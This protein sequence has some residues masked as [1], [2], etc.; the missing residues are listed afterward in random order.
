MLIS[1]SL[2][3]HF[4]TT[5]HVSSFFYL[6]IDNSISYHLICSMKYRHIMRWT[7]L[8]TT[9]KQLLHLYNHVVKSRTLVK[10]KQPIVNWSKHF[11]TDYQFYGVWKI[12][13]LKIYA[14]LVD[15]LYLLFFHT[16]GHILVISFEKMVNITFG[17]QTFS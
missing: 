9:S 10:M 12:R 1:L 6:S 17:L 11:V 2:R 5:K 3:G 15:F 7:S 8:V 14:K 13:A 16:R 4:S